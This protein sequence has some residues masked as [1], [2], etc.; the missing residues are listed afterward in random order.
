M[1][2]SGII[3]RVDELGRIVLPREM[4]KLMNI[5]DGSRLIISLEND[6]FILTKHSSMNTL[7]QYADL[8]VKAISISVENEVLLCD[9]DKVLFSNK[10]RH[11][12]KKLSKL[13]CDAIYKKDTIIKRVSD[14]SEMISIFIENNEDYACELIVPI[15]KD[16]DG[17]GAIIILATD[18]KCFKDDAIKVCK[19]FANFLS[20][21]IV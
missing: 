16:G 18:D 2:N 4:R 3:R 20:E 1:D 19:S 11:I 6:K 17:L 21:F 10:K 7:V 8:V 15:S 12:D 13:V 9:N 5:R 14:A